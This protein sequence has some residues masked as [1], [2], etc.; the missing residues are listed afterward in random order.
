MAECSEQRLF[1]AVKQGGQAVELSKDR[2][3]CADALDDDKIRDV[4]A[5][6]RTVCRR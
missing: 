6:V 3:R 1:R 2:L 5:F 4:L